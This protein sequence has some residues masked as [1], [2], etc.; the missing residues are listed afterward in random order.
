MIQATYQWDRLR[1]RSLWLP[2]HVEIRAVPSAFA[3]KPNRSHQAWYEDMINMNWKKA[4]RTTDRLVANQISLE[5][6]ADDFFDAILQAN[7]NAHW[8]GRDLV[9]KEVTEF[10]ITDMLRARG[11]ADDDANYLQNFM[12]D[13]VAGRYTDEEGNLMTTQL[14]NRQ[15]LYLGKARGIAGQASVDALDLQTKIYWRLGGTEAHCQDCPTLAAI[16]PFY[17][18]DLYATPGSCA[19]PCLGNCK[20]HLEFKIEDMLV[21]TIKPVELSI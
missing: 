3:N 15:R 18:D 2:P 14:L 17:K 21:T 12:D 19:T 9:S 1:Q 5:R 8:I 11:I 4:K 16:S 7:A 6:W 10:N 20:C 13:I